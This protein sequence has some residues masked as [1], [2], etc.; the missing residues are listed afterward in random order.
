MS[1][2]EVHTQA[3]ID[4]ERR[5]AM[6]LD[7]QREAATRALANRPGFDVAEIDEAEFERGLEKI[8]LRQRRLQRILDTV[9]IE[10]VH[11]GNPDVGNNRK[12]FKK[13]M[14][15]QGGAE[16]LRTFFRLTMKHVE[17]A[18]TVE[19]EAY[20]SVTVKMGIFDNVGRLVCVRSGNCNTREK[21]FEKSGG[22][23]I[24]RDAREMVH[25]CLAMAEK[26]A[27]TLGT[28]EATGATGFFAAEEEM[29]KALAQD[30]EPA[31][32]MATPEARQEMYN[33]AHAAGFKKAAAW[34]G[35]C[36]EV[37]GHAF[38]GSK[39]DVEKIVAAVNKANEAQA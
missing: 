12:A 16:E 31:M 3:E 10:G 27:G 25:N 7:H 2:L 1:N 17:P 6:A 26:R 28:R 4:G 21:R 14:L 34:E 13:P 29:D 30:A 9:L 32:E 39:S 18:E 5:G 33:L 19:T 22:G 8:K 11:Y 20:V 36:Q 24:F 37:L 38:N 15:Y 23:Y 35:L